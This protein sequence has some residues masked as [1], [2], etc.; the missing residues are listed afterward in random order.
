MST[1]SVDTTLTQ[2]LFDS[3]TSPITISEGVT[4]TLSEYINNSNSAKYFILGGTNITFEGNKNAI[5]LDSIIDYPGLFQCTVPTYIVAIQNLGVLVGETSTLATN[6]AWF[7]QGYATSDV[8]GDSGI[9]VK[10][11]YSTGEI[12]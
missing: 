12:F 10:N 8:A 4:V 5:I 1:I 3:Y 2:G 11:C 7:V 6:N 9:T